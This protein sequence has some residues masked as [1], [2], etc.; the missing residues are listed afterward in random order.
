MKIKSSSI[1]PL[2]Y[3]ITISTIILFVASSIRHILFQSTAF[4]LGIFDNGVYLISQGKTPYISFR[5]LHLLGDH[6]AWIF[7]PIALLYFIFPSVYWLFIIQAIALSFGALPTWYL[8]KI[9]GLKQ[10]QANTVALVYLLY[11]LI[12][13]IN[14]FDFHA[15]VIALPAILWAILAAKVNKL[16]WFCTAIIIILGSKAVLALTVIALGIWLLIWQKKRSYGIIAIITGVSWFMVATQI[17]IP[18]FSGEE[19][20][21]VGRYS[22]LG[23]SVFE[24]AK[25]L[26]LKP[27]IILSH[28]F[29]LVNLEYLLLLLAPVIW[30]LSW[31]HLSNLIPAIPTLFLNLLTDYQPQKDL[32]HQYSLSIL[33]FLILTVIAS[34]ATGNSWLKNNRHIIIWSLIGFLALA[35]PYYFTSKYLNDLNTWKAT[36]EAL[37]M[38]NSQGSV[39]TAAQFA[40][41]LTHRQV[42][43]LATKDSTYNDLTK[44]DY[45]LL[46]LDNPG[47]NS[48]QEVV[49][50]LINKAKQNSHLKLIFE[51]DNIFLFTKVG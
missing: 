8:A 10:S 13:N 22:F 42:L 25:N 38:I 6:A 31:R 1:H 21:A 35:K 29:T 46:N 11:P 33:P 19:A 2:V 43:K 4:D 26:I 28:L 18:H 30:G 40:P 12:F 23:N 51:Q 49:L 15:E 16:W 45:I 3:L 32:I 37:M 14:L 44:F 50:N 20:A 39:L 9:A 24:I 34:L 48:N 7:Y 47:W 36:N 17:I 5:G 41:H 27:Q